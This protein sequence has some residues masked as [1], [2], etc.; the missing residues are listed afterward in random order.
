VTAARLGGLLLA[1]TWAGCSQAQGPPGPSL[2]RT[3]EGPSKALGSVL[4]GG[5]LHVRQKPDFCGEAVTESWLSALGMH[6]DQDQVF[7]LSRMDPARGMGATTR[8]LGVALEQLGFDVGPVWHTIPAADGAALD[9]A[10]SELHADLERRVPSIVC[11]HYDSSPRTTEHFRLVLGYDAGTDEVVY[12][13]PA[14]DSGAYRRLPRREFL[15]LWPLKY[16]S[17]RWSVIRLRLAGTPQAP[18]PQ[19]AGA[20]PADYAQ[21]VLTLRPR[22]PP[23]FSVVVQP[24]FVVIG[25][26]TPERVQA[27]GEHV[28]RWAV[29]RL[30][31]DF[32][33]RSPGRILDIWLFKDD[34]SYERNTRALFGKSPSTPFGYYSSEDDALVMNIA[35]GGGTLVHELVHPFI[36]ANFPSCPAWFNEGLGSLFEQSAD[37]DGHIVGLTN[38]RLAGLQRA[39]RHKKLPTF[40]ALMATTSRQFYDEDRGSNYAQARYLLY[41]LQERD[42]LVAYYREFLSHQSQDPTGFFSLLHVL[43]EEDPVRFQARWERFVLGLHFP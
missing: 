23:G 8:E 30:A 11:M 9:Q 21:H 2:T 41:Y 7:A 6:V 39:I 24:P 36:E 42:L 3:A 19:A 28:V 29:E 22:V 31:R 38:W 35:T 18:P 33:P 25:D 1:L 37:R 40:R 27:S 26:D 15:A 43:D 17:G 14:R 16:E 32:F 20:K 10:F 12:H 5:V 34:V 13:E 4:I